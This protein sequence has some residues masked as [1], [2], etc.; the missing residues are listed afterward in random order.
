[1]RSKSL[2]II[3]LTIAFVGCLKNRSEISGK[4]TNHVRGEYILLDELKS[5]ELFTVDSSLMEDNGNFSFEIKTKSPAFYLLKISRSNFLPLILSPGEKINIEADHDSL[6]APIS[7][8]GSKDSELLAEFNREMQATVRKLYSLNAAYMQNT[9]ST[10]TSGLIDSLDNL[11]QTHLAG[12]NAYTRDFIGRNLTSLASLYALYQQVAPGVNVLN[13][14]RDLE[15]FVKV[16]SAMSKL[17][18]DYEPVKALHAQV[19]EYLASRSPETS[20]P[21][22]TGSSA[23][24][25]ALPDPKGDTIRLSSQRG[26]Y[27]LLDFWASWCG[28]CRQENPNI[29]KAYNE[30]HGRGFTVFQVSLDK[31]REAWMN[32]IKADQLDRWIHVSD[33][34]YWKSEVVP[35]YRLEKIPSNFLL[36]PDG[37]I[38]AVDL[39]GEN[40]HSKLAELF[41][42]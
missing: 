20:A 39:R 34:K 21:V 27:V 14:S 22:S 4:L 1:M 17:Y 11:A 31:T 40:L 23:P 35:L 26:S 32:G 30:F 12:L 41:N 18:P 36:D 5:N 37:K 9:D 16:D 28:P 25:I 8:T 42:K 2:Y 10:R 13:P 7:L 33:L 15:Y 3:L 19:E 6:N 38:I 24:E 29:V